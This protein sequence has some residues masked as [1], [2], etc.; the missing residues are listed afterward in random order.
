MLNTAIPLYIYVYISSSY[1][2]YYYY[3]F[4]SSKTRIHYFDWTPGEKTLSLHTVTLSGFGES[5]EYMLFFGRK[6]IFQSN[7]L[8]P[9]VRFVIK[10]KKGFWFYVICF[11]RLV[12]YLTTYTTHLTRRVISNLLIFRI[13]IQQLKNTLKIHFFFLVCLFLYA[14]IFKLSWYIYWPRRL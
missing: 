5:T 6:V 13:I 4:P 3:Y 2:Y 8:P 9:K 7:L 12:F 11:I 1:Y 10:L 14:F